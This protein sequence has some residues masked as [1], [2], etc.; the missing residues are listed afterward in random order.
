[1]TRPQAVLFDIDGT[2]V[3]TVDLHAE[4][5]HEIFQRFGLSATFE[6][7]RRQIGK[8][9]D[10]L[11]P[12]LVPPEFLAEHQE[13]MEQAR[14]E[15]FTRDYMPRVKPF[16]K[17]RELFERLK[18][19]GIRVAL[20]TSGKPDEVAH[21]KELLNVADL[22]DADTTSDEAE[23]SKPFPDIFE[24]AFRK[25]GL[26]DPSLAL[27]VGD[28]PYDAEAARGAG[29][30]SL[31]VLSGG[32]PEAAL[33]QAGAIAVYRDPAHL[34]EEYDTSPFATGHA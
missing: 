25:L 8:G 28:T 33:R 34:L 14:A 9:G 2:L 17:V 30:P 32:F 31:G 4:A 22:L 20:A 16:P 15:L 29:L 13:E 19:D 24:A 21:H 3:D 1:M 12:G 18:A 23:R 11:L 27:V 6:E 5:W 7:I 10:Q 26:S